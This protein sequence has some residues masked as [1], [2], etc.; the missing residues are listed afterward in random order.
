[1]TDTHKDFV[2]EYVLKKSRE[3]AE[4]REQAIIDFMHEN[5]CTPS[6]IELIIT[7]NVDGTETTRVAL[8][9]G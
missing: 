3:V 9:D 6:D 1:M 8:K 7:R 2:R 4:K 5:K